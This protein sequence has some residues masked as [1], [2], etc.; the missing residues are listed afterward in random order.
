MNPGDKLGNAFEIERTLGSGAM[1][2]VYRAVYVKTGQRV[3]IKIINPALSRSDNAL[4]RFEREIEVLKQL[5]HPNIVRLLASG[6]Y[7]KTPFYAMEYIEGETLDRVLERRGRYTWEEVVELG[8]QLCAALQHAHTHGIVHRDLKPSN[9]MVTK[10]GVLKLTDFGIAK[11]LDVTALTSAHCTVGTASYMSPE[12]CRGE[13]NLSHKSDLYSLGVMFYELLTGKKPFQ[14]ETAMDMFVLHATGKFERP[15]RLVL[16]V[17]IW[18]DTL[19]CQLMEKKPEKRPLDAETVANT[20]TQVVEKVTAGRSAGVEVAKTRGRERPRGGSAMDETDKDIVARIRGEK[21]RR[22]VDPFYTK[23]WF[24][25]LAA[26]ALLS[27]LAYLFYQAFQPNSPE[28]LVAAARRLMDSGDPEKR[29]QAREGPIQEYLAHYRNRDD[30]QTRQMQAWADEMDLALLERQL[31]NRRSRGLPPD[32]DEERATLEVERTENSGDL[33]KA[34]AA[35]TAM[36]EKYRNDPEK[37]RWSA[38]AGRH[39]AEIADVFQREQNLDAK[40]AQSF[41]Q[42]EN[43]KASTEPEPLAIDAIRAENIF[44]DPWTAQQRWRELKKKKEGEAA[45]R[46][47]YLLAAYKERSLEPASAEDKDKRKQD[48]ARL[49]QVQLEK[50]RNALKL[51]N[52]RGAQFLAQ[53]ILEIYGGD[54]AL[55]EQL[56]EARNLLKEASGGE[57]APNKSN[58]IPAEKPSS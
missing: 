44:E 12:Q 37:R 54:M 29:N 7:H 28:R 23:G 18:L 42:A 19:I 26:V 36:Q 55:S 46:P 39:L 41:K 48:R 38:L 20:L 21:R 16:D 2:D 30:E 11:D 1:G 8:T 15:S 4:A 50:A 34:M 35:W 43:L 14:A 25:S 24:V 5:K 31:T 57:R 58:P 51:Q 53:E 22:K 52:P 56:Q 9:V 27:A 6:R 33:R 45:G 32:S 47:W 3:A 49:I 17:P 13:R 10:D 40:V